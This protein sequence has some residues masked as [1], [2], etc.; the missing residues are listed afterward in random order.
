MHYFYI[1]TIKMTKPIVNLSIILQPVN[2]FALWLKTG[3]TLS[4]RR[5]LSYRNQSLD[6]LC[7]LMDWFLYDIGLCHER[8][9]LTFQAMRRSIMVRCSVVF[10]LTFSI[11]GHTA[12]KVSKYRVICGPYFPV[13]GLNAGKYGPEITPYLD[14]FHAVPI[15]SRISE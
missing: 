14:T 4:W 5:P 11:Y 10:I 2:W 7:K 3:L 12:W 1:F 15:V 9:N 8:V 13:F 6:L